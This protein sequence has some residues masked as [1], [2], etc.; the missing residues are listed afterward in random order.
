MKVFLERCSEM[1]NEDGSKD[2]KIEK[3]IL[4][5][6]TSKYRNG[7]SVSEWEKLSKKA[8]TTLTPTQ[9]KTLTE[10]NDSLKKVAQSVSSQ[11][12][13]LMKGVSMPDIRSLIPDL[14]KSFLSL[15]D[16]SLPPIETY[17]PIPNLEYINLKPDTSL[18]DEQRQQ[19]A[20]LERLLE[21]QSQQ[22]QNSDLLRLIEPRYDRGKRVITFSNTQ[23]RLIA[24]SDNEIICKKLFWDGRPVRRPVEKGDIMELLGTTD[25]KAF[26]NKVA[27]LNKH[28]EKTTGVEKLFDFVD[29]KLWFN[30]KYVELP[31]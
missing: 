9:K 23:I 10:A 28:V 5:I 4:S 11:M 6:D 2:Q 31:L 25:K 18:I 14:P 22:Q 8:S 26:Y 16:L 30:A 21:V 20:L 13:G 1:S 12:T 7:L 3:P 24:N 17:R 29:K 27:S 15:S 19:T